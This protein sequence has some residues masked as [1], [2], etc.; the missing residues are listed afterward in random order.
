MREEIENWKVGEKWIKTESIQI[1]DITADETIL[2]E[3]WH[4]VDDW[5]DEDYVLANVDR[6]EYA[7]VETEDI[8]RQLNEAK[9][10]RLAR[11]KGYCTSIVSI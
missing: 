1:E 7:L 8:R 11:Q 2:T 9:E 4:E 10:A 6:E 5:T 3:Q